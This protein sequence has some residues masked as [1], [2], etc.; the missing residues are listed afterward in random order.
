MKSVTYGLAFFFCVLL[1]CPQAA[2]CGW[3]AISPDGYSGSTFAGVWQP[4][5]ELRY[6]AASDGV[7][8]QNNGSSWKAI[9]SPTN[10][11]LTSVWGIAYT[12]LFAV[13]RGGD[14]LR[15]NNVGWQ[16]QNNATSQPL[17]RL[18]GEPKAWQQPGQV[19]VATGQD[20][21]FVNA[22]GWSNSW[23]K[24]TTA[25]SMEYHGV[26]G[27][28]DQEVF[29]GSVGG[30][31]W[32]GTGSGPDD[33][34]WQSMDLGGNATVYGIWGAS[35]T[36]L[37]AVGSSGMIW[38]SNGTDWNTMTSPTTKTLRAIWGAAADQ[39]YAVGDAGTIL[40]FDGTAWV[41]ETSPTTQ[42][43]LD[44]TG[45]SVD[46]VTIVGE[47]GTVLMQYQN[48]GTTPIAPLL[49]LLDND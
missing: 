41:A 24:S 11:D 38:H 9:Q 13:S 7:L 30:Q 20:G 45:S 40:R 32:K 29:A 21:I 1:G 26:T 4:S 35:D 10:Q 31:V 48:N 6:I 39:I 22:D 25:S 8:L 15:Y 44:V 47:G 17:Y 23:T 42:N 14:L 34:T 16:L 3:K 49:M 5:A 19:V 37:Y 33:L 27:F 43:L 28:S 46:D 36:D 12:S 18:W 2:W